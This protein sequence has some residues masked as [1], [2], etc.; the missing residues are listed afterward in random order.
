MFQPLEETVAIRD[1]RAYPELVGGIRRT[2]SGNQ[3]QIA[4]VAGQPQYRLQSV[5]QSKDNG[6]VL[7][8]IAFPYI[9]GSA[10][11]LNIVDS[12]G[13]NDVRVSVAV[14]VRVRGQVVLEEV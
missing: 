11:R 2:P 7:R 14:P 4:I 6:G 5:T 12:D 8:V 13:N 10:V 1:F 3:V 9:E